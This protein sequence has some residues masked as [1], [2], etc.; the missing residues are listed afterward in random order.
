M[1]DHQL[2]FCTRKVK[3][4]KFNKYNNV[5]LRSFE[6]YTINLFVEKL[7]KVYCSN[8]EQFFLVNEIAPSKEIKIKNITQIWFDREIVELIHARKKLFLKFKK[9][10]LHIDEE[11]YK[12]VKYQVQNLIRKKK[13]Q[14]YETKLRQKINKPNELWKTLKSMGLP[15]KAVTASNICLKD[16]NQIVFND[17]KNCS[18]FKNNF[19]SL[20]QNLASK[21][22][23]LPNIFTESNIAS[24][25]NNNAVS[26]DLNFQLLEMSP[27][28]T[29]SILKGLNPSK[30]AG[31]DNLSGKFLKD[32]A[33]VLAQPISQLCNL[34]IKLNSFPRSCKIAKVKPLFEK[35]SQADPQNYRPISLLPLL[36]KII[37]R[38]VHDQTENFLSKNKIL[39]RFQLGFRKNYSTNTCLGHLT[40][41]ITTGF[42]KGLFTGM[43]LIDL[44]KVFDTIDH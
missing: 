9:S 43:I 39:Y 17:I 28:K 14:F 13:R 30:A 29:S 8:Y 36:S 5:F 40:D 10:K 22:P 27:E 6:H 7:Q 4:A 33:H 44:Q 38:I 21:L 18:I 26:K 3:Q 37:E 32:G 35:G 41:K 2:I 25:Y 1:S 42:E 11:N 34:S 31:I 24:Y 19:S 15:S 16:K 20:A 12:K 23:L